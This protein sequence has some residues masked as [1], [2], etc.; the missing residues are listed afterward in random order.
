[1]VDP[2]CPQADVPASAGSDPGEVTSEMSR[3]RAALAVSEG[4][5]R[6]VLKGETEHTIVITNGEERMPAGMPA[7]A[8]CSAVRRRRCCGGTSP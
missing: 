3:L 2:D 5:P 7:C 8:A 4:R 6:T 1:M